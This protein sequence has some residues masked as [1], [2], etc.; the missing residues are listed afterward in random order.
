MSVRGRTLVLLGV[1]AT[2]NAAVWTFLEVGL[3]LARLPSLILLSLSTML[4]TA[5]VLRKHFR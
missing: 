3:G 1:L 2:F 4:V 5:V